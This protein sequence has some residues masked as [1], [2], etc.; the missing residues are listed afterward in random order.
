MSISHEDVGENL[1]RIVISGRLDIPGTDEIA[2]KL[3]ALANAPKKGV[4]VDLTSLQFL[5]SIGIRALI[6]S[7]KTVKQRGGKMVLVV[8]SGSSVVMSLE[9]TGVNELIPVF[10]S[11]ADAE[12]A[13][14]A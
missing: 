10:K 14:L 6:N 3:A 9:A 12:R 4:V 11:A 13:A 2:E 5:A 1:R 7:A 8:L